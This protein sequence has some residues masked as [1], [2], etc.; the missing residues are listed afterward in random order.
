[1]INKVVCYRMKNIFSDFEKRNLTRMELV[2]ET[3]TLG[4]LFVF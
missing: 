3:C 1:M 4:K 2:F